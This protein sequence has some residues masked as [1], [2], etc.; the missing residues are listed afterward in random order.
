LPNRFKYCRKASNEILLWQKILGDILWSG[1]FDQLRPQRQVRAYY[2]AWKAIL[3]FA[4]LVKSGK[5]DEC[6]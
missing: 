2:D 3:Q 1:S 5:K 4:E 6:S